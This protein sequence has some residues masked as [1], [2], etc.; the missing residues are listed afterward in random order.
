EYRRALVCRDVTDAIARLLPGAGA[1][2][3]EN[4]ATLT[5]L[6]E[7]WLAG[8]EP[9]W[10]EIHAGEKRHRVPL[11]GYPFERKRHFVDPPV[12]LESDKSAGISPVVIREA[13]EGAGASPRDR[14]AAKL[15]S[16]F[17]ELSGLELHAEHRAVPLI[18]LGFDSLFLTQVRQAFESEF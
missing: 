4:T 17:H 3:P 8:G 12:R 1:T 6:G 5:A 13:G 15:L 14:I 10:S 11:P 16:L 9:D 18:E 2:T 7:Q